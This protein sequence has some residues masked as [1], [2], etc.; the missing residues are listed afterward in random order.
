VEKKKR[1]YIL[2]YFLYFFNT[3]QISSHYVYT[4]GMSASDFA[5]FEYVQKRIV[6]HGKKTQQN[7]E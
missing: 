2:I 4:Y 6:E 3:W 1:S 7:T 5:F